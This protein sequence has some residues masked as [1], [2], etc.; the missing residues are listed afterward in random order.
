MSDGIRS[1]IDENH[2]RKDAINGA[3]SGDQGDPADSLSDAYG[4][5]IGPM[6]GDEPEVEEMR[7]QRI[8]NDRAQRGKTP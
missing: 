5:L 7:R 8:E 1:E 3:T 2:K 4:G 6:G